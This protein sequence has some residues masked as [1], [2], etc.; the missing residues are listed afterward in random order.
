MTSFTNG[1]VTFPVNI[2]EYITNNFAG[3]GS[4][5]S[6]SSGPVTGSSNFFVQQT[7]DIQGQASN[8]LGDLILASSTGIVT[9][10]G[11]LHVL[12]GISASNGL[13]GSGAGGGS[14][15]PVTGSSAFFV[16][17]GLDVQGYLTNSLSNKIMISGNLQV[18][19]SGS[20]FAFNTSSLPGISF[21]IKSS[22]S[23]SAT[24]AFQVVNSNGTILIQMQDNGSGYS[25]GQWGTNTGGSAVSPAFAVLNNNAGLFIPNT[26]QLGFATSGKEAGHA[27]AKQNWFFSG[28]L[29][30]NTLSASIVATSQDLILSSSSTSRVTISG[31]LSSLG[32]I[33]LSQSSAPVP[34][35][36]FGTL[37]VTSST[38]DL[39]FSGAT[40]KYQLTPPATG[41]AG[42][43]GSFNGQ[44]SPVSAPATS[45]AYSNL[46]VSS[47]DNQL[48]F[49]NLSGTYKISPASNNYDPN[50]YIEDDDM[51]WYGNNG[52]N[53]GVSSMYAGGPVSFW[54]AG[55]GTGGTT[56]G[57]VPD[58]VRTAGHPG[59]ATL[60]T[61]STYA[62]GTIQIW[63][64]FHTISGGS[65]SIDNEWI[66]RFPLSSSA[67]ATR[68]TAFVGMGNSATQGTPSSGIWFSYVDSVNGAKWLANTP[69]T[70]V[71]TGILFQA[72]AW[73]RM[74]IKV[75][76]PGLTASF[77][78]NDNNV[79]VITTNVP[80]LA[81]S[82]F[83]PTLYLNKIFGASAAT[84]D[85]DRY[86]LRLET[87][88]RN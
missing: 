71:D 59:I 60:T 13:T 82:L 37:Y 38:G 11:T 33:S 5:G 88:S 66:V 36:G 28:N 51:L 49:N 62:S 32:S 21:L 79:A 53:V 10:S 25:Q 75:D 50:V 27:D 76:A 8:T 69:G 46:F 2:I 84:C 70:T 74:G 44:L 12:G 64:N 83:G 52:T 73:Y 3:S 65:G 48:Y 6:G 4:G 16:Q 61:C 56:P 47:S 24:T 63:R 40:G 77:F 18:G 41:A 29:N 80:N 58:N 45:S 42:P 7:L 35:S 31:N 14:S 67:T 22:G 15:G 9:I 1:N 30:I 78:I 86:Y 81:N 54:V 17:Q 72:N 19:I 87:T 57:M 55:S 34:A 26:A 20:T 23:T 39:Y 43:T 68:Y 85:L